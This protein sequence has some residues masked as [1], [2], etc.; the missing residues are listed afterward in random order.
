MNILGIIASSKFGD[1]G[2]F[3]SIATV[4]LSSTAASVSFTS[5]PN[6][7][8]HLQLR[9]LTRETW[10]IYSNTASLIF[11]FNSDTAGNYARHQLRGTGA[12][13]SAS[14]LTSTT[15]PAFGYQPGGGV[16]ASIFGATVVD[17][18]DY[19]D[20]NKYKT[21]R[22]LNGN[23]SNG[24]GTIGL[25]SDVWMNT[26]AITSIQIYADQTFTANS[27]FALYGIRSA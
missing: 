10:N 4:S 13:V 26:A 5:I 15:N 23:D 3:E 18:L 25:F 7:Y 20:T 16:A 24:A 19:K 2:D 27:H 6:T 21:V 22:S 9:M 17:I 11:S 8:T 1:A 14:A 12:T